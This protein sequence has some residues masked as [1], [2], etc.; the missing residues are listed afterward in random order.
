M[1]P[2]IRIII[3]CHNSART[4]RRA[5]ASLE[6]QTFSD[7]EV[8]LVDDGS[9]DDTRNTLL[10]FQAH[11]RLRLTIL[12]QRH[13]ARPPPATGAWKTVTPLF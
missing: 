11:S 12:S 2:A 9:T 8:V 13:A 7:F 1:Q 5:L 10:D 4:I 3:P 6:Q